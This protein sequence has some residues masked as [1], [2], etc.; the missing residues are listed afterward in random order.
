M[1]DNISP[2]PDRERIIKAALRERLLRDHV[3]DP[4]KI[5]DMLAVAVQNVR[6]R[7]SL[8]GWAVT[9]P[10][11][12]RFQSDARS[13]PGWIRQAPSSEN[14]SAYDRLRRANAESQPE[15][16]QT[17]TQDAEDRPH[18]SAMDRL[19]RANRESRPLKQNLDGSWSPRE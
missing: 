2:G 18:E 15:R 6:V 1:L 17:T 3:L 10:D 16:T 4:A 7:M 11:A 5:E 8:T 13:R 9:E 19:K 14:E 12:A